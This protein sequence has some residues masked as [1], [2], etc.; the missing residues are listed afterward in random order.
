[1]IDL[2]KVAQEEIN[3]IFDEKAT[4]Y[5]QEAADK[6]V[7]EAID[8]L[9][10]YGGQLKQQIKECVQQNLSFDPTQVKVESLKSHMKE[11]VEQTL[12]DFASKELRKN[13][14]EYLEKNMKIYN[15]PEIKLSEI[16][17]EVEDGLE[18]NA[19]SLERWD[20]YYNMEKDEG[21]RWL[22]F[23]YLGENQSYNSRFDLQVGI[24]L[25]EENEIRSVMGE[26]DF[27]NVN[28]L[29][30]SLHAN[31]VKLIVDVEDCPERWTNED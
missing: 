27:A 20:I 12:N 28:R 1:M 26:T 5:V 8:D 3:K 16:M 15:K 2:A 29:L 9:F 7:R 22:R 19:E 21:Y 13:L 23:G 30:F 18:I 11:V 10:R 14:A 17:R 31:S 6:A 4:Q 25:N 24:L